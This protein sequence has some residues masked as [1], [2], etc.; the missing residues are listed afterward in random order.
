MSERT[1]IL[2]FKRI[3]P[4]GTRGHLWSCYGAPGLPTRHAGDG[5]AEFEGSPNLR[6][7]RIDIVKLCWPHKRFVGEKHLGLSC[8][9]FVNPSHMDTT[10]ALCNYIVYVSVYLDYLNVL[11][12]CGFPDKI[13]I[14]NKAATVASQKTEANDWKLGNHK[15]HFA[16]THQPSGNYNSL[17]ATN[18]RRTQR[19]EG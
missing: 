14:H 2:Y 8:Q 4:R 5:G 7:P 19:D 10:L 9:S 18:R 11:L 17:T 12:I 1:N 15:T 16:Q 6:F 3:M 13:I